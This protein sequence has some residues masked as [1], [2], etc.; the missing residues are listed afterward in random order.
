[1]MAEGQAASIV[2]R[3][4]PQPAHRP[5]PTQVAT[6]GL[7]V[8]AE[9]LQRGR[10]VRLQFAS[11]GFL[12]PGVLAA[13]GARAFEQVDANPRTLPTEAFDLEIDGQSLQG[14]WEW[15]DSRSEGLSPNGDCPLPGGLGARHALPVHWAPS[16]AAHGI[17]RLH[18]TRRAI[19]IEV[20]TVADGT[21][22]FARWLCIT[23]RGGQPAA[24]GRCAPWCGL[25]WGGAGSPQPSV[26]QHLPAGAAPFVLGR[27]A[28]EDW[29]QEGAFRWRQLPPDILRIEHIKG[30]SG[31]DDPAFLLRN[32]LTGEVAVGALA[33]SGNWALSFRTRPLDPAAAW[34]GAAAWLEVR[35]EPLAD[36]PQRVI[37]PG[38]TV[39]TPAMHIGVLRGSVDAAVRALHDHERRT[40]LP[41]QP[42]GRGERVI[43]NHWGYVAHDM[44]PAYL[45]AEIDIAAEIGAELF[46]VDAGWFSPLGGDWWNTVGEW[47]P[48]PERLPEGLTPI[49]EHAHAKGLLLG[50]WVEAERVAPNSWVA[51]ERPEWVLARDGQPVTPTPEGGGTLNLSHPDC[52]AWLEAEINRIVD[53]YGIDMF[54]LDYNFY[55]GRGGENARDGFTESGFWRHYEVLYGIFDRLR[56]RHPEL[57]LE[58]CAGGGGRKDLG[59]AARFHTYWTSD[60]QLLPRTVAVLNGVSLFL[61]PERLNRLAGVGQSAQLHGDLDTQLRVPL[62]AHYAIS[63]V[64]PARDVWNPRQRERVIHAIRLYKEFVRPW[65]P[66]CRVY[67]HTPELIGRG[68]CAACGEP[69]GWC[70]LEY[71]A[72]DGARAM[73][74]LFRLA[75]EGDP[76]WHFRARGLE[77][78][79]RYRVTWDNTGQSAEI[80]GW[81]LANDGLLV[82]CERPLT[83]ELLLLERV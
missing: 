30:T 83:S 4:Q 69:Q 43:Y 18:N 67:H 31:N 42:Q 51:R 70:V 65:L 45:L 54:R 77:R 2:F 64:T 53:E 34:E 61:P 25:L 66:T 46:M 11:Q 33:W 48:D 68:R 23:N 71:A 5:Q 29:G 16:S 75:G 13:H 32:D 52:A 76:M 27:C 17:M 19:D 82:T 21:G 50:L 22:M 28:S 39:T 36:S 44:N 24:L 80:D 14:G 47:R 72:A 1:M 15:V 6:S 56:E 73:V 78:G 63:G 8:V 20:H 12:N 41:P 9:S 7:G 3:E 38:E 74:G 81:R 40:V 79:A 60:W 49:R 57:L 37:A 26:T 55:P 62:F 10:L 35:A 58:N 59:I